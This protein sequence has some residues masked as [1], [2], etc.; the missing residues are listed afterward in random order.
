M[1][2]PNTHCFLVEDAQQ[3]GLGKAVILYNLRYWL[4]KNQA[5][6]KHFYDGC[7]WTY[8]SLDAFCE[9]LPYLTRSTLGRYLTE[10]EKDGVIKKGNYNKHKYDR[11]GWYTVC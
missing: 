3:H 7:Y 8:N 6:N 2:E 10:L 5:N 4:K 9:L 1:S 11:T